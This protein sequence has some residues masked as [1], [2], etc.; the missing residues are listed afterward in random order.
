MDTCSTGE[1]AGE[2]VGEAP[3]ASPAPGVESE[4][5]ITSATGP[6]YNAAFVLP[7][8]LLPLL[9]LPKLVAVVPPNPGDESLRPIANDVRLRGNGN[10]NGGE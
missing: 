5:A 7:L 9:P 6:L 3:T 2:I 1:G 8:L 4:L 10:G